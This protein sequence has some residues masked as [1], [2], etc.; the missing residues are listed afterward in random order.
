MLMTMM[1]SFVDKGRGGVTIGW[2]GCQTQRHSLSSLQRKG[3]PCSANSRGKREL[4]GS[5]PA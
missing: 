5:Y 1:M 3:Q 4:A 2:P